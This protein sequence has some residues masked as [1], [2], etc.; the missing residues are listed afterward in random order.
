VNGIH[1]DFEE[2]RLLIKIFWLSGRIAIMWS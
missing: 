1:C 2:E